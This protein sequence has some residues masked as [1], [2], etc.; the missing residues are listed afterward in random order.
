[1]TTTREL[2]AGLAMA[3]DFAALLDPSSIDPAERAKLYV[4][5]ADALIEALSATGKTDDGWIEWGGGKC[6]VDPHTIVKV[7][8]RD[9]RVSPALPACA[10]I[11]PHTGMDCDIIAY[12]VAP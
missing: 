7:R 9:R 3:G 4:R 12:R 10:S 5:Y 11:W 2:L 6:P 1:M 8:F